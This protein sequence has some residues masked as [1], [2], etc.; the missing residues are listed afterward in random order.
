MRKGQRRGRRKATPASA[1]IFADLNLPNPE[2]WLAKAELARRISDLIGQRG[3]SQR[4]AAAVLGVSQPQVSAVMRGLLEGFTA[5]RLFR[6]LNKLGQEIR[7]VV[8][9]SKRRRR[10]SITVEAA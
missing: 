5:D 7:I 4:Q 1:N 10:A 9:P 8:G 6:F 3:L 2:E